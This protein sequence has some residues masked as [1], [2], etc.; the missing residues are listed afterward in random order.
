M[1]DGQPHHCH[2]HQHQKGLWKRQILPR[3]VQATLQLQRHSPLALA[4]WSGGGEELG[5]GGGGWGGGR[6]RARVC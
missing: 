3:P 2:N 4:S 6:E 5:G 1:G